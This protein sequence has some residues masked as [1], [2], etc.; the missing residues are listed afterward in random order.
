ML[1]ILRS[2]SSPQAAA[3][4]DAALRDE[5]LQ[6]IADRMAGDDAMARASLAMAV[7]MGATM[8]RTIMA[9]EPMC[10]NECGVVHAKIAALYRTALSE[11]PESETLP[12]ETVPDEL[13]A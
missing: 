6:P 13:A 1:L 10:G 11:S 8:L 3:I 5:I 4:V 2:A 9:V 12:D 7:W